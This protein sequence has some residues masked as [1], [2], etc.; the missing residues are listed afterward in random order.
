MI[1]S[2]YI[3]DPNNN[4]INIIDTN[5]DNNPVI[6]VNP[7]NIAN[8][9][10]S[11]NVNTIGSNI[12]T[13]SSYNTIDNETSIINIS[14]DSNAINSSITPATSS[15]MYPVAGAPSTLQYLQ[16]HAVPCSTLHQVVPA[17]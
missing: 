3:I 9:I 10:N 4:S 6:I 7:N 15:S 13:K 16:V 11:I 2:N 5:N 14:I 12:I 17:I 1:N 8:N